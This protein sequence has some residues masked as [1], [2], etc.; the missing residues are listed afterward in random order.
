VLFHYL[1]GKDDASWGPNNKFRFPMRGGS[2]AVWTGLFEAIDQTKFRLDVSVSEV[3]A[4]AKQI[5]LSDG[6]WW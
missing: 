3:N 2:G 4:D 1:Q 6:K 5:T